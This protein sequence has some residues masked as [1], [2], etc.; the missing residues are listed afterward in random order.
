MN[1]ELVITI[2]SSDYASTFHKLQ[3]AKHN[4]LIV[5]HSEL[6]VL[7]VELAAPHV[8]HAATLFYDR[9]KAICN[10]DNRMSSSDID[11]SNNINHSSSI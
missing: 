5:G 7:P 10:F 8:Q 3:T 9:N 4:G 1:Y 2:D 6:D 11:V